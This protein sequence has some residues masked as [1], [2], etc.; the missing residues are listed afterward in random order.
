MTAGG[1]PQRK[2]STYA[3]RRGGIFMSSATSPARTLQTCSMFS[4]MQ[5][6]QRCSLQRRKGERT[7]CDL[8]RRAISVSWVLLFLTPTV[9]HANIWGILRARTPS[10]AK[11]GSVFF[12]QS[13]CRT[14]AI[15]G[16]HG[17]TSAWCIVTALQMRLYRP[18]RL[19]A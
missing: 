2:R 11:I 5:R 18:P 15:L 13:T 1:S 8:R 12:V 7:M 16:K 4:R 3:Q 19:Q 6:R 17:H 14:T 10:A 9:R